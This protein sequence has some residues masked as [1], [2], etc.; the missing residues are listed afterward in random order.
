MSK[1]QIMT[2][3]LPIV[4][5]APRI[6]VRQ[7]STPNPTSYE[8]QFSV[9]TIRE[10]VRAGYTQERFRALSPLQLIE[11]SDKSPFA[12][13]PWYSD[14]SFDAPGFENDFYLWSDHSVI[15]KSRVYW[16][17]GKPLDFTASFWIHL[18]PLGENRTSVQTLTFKPQVIVGKT[19]GLLNP[20]GP[21]N[22]YVDVPPSS[23][24]EYS[25]L[26]LVGS[27]LGVRDMPKLSVPDPEPSSK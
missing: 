9:R 12:A 25:I 5:C 1:V 20:H 7:L 22:I 13:P 3:L 4:G 11:K 16:S 15:S 19:L 24:E 27:K 23:L 10:A 2:L 21:A 26:L 6:D 14:F 18:H 8:F 17:R